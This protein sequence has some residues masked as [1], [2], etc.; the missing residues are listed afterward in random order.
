MD[1]DVAIAN[2]LAA[3]PHILQSQSGNRAPLTPSVRHRA[4]YDR[5]LTVL[6][7]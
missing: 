3:N 2:V 4:T 5:S 7:K 1:N 6:K